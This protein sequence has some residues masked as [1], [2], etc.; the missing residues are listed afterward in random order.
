M[1]NINRSTAM[2]QSMGNLTVKL[3]KSYGLLRNNPNAV[4][5]WV[6]LLCNQQPERVAFTEHGTTLL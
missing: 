1:S 5:K 6:T 3:L 4:E 2:F